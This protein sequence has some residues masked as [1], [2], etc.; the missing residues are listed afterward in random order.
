MVPVV[1]INHSPKHQYRTY[2]VLWYPLQNHP[3]R[4][5]IAGTRGTHISLPHTP[6][7]DIL[8]T[9]GTHKKKSSPQ[10]KYTWY[11][12]YPH[13]AR[14]THEFRTYLLPLYPIHK[15]TH[16]ND[17]CW[18][19]WYPYIAPFTHKRKVR[20][21]LLIHRWTILGTRGTHRWTT[22]PPSQT[23][24]QDILA[25]VVPITQTHTED[26]CWY[27]W[28]PYTYIPPLQANTGLTYWYTDEVS[29]VPV[30]PKYGPTSYPL[31]ATN[32]HTHT[33]IELQVHLVLHTH[34]YTEKSNWY[35]W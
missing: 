16:R 23:R 7:Q 34:T 3:D 20:T 19:P 33:Q 26:I 27:P 30:V 14:H 12:W 11:P 29:L 1:P 8:G 21:N 15:H 17:L 9:R 10:K 6:I 22:H 24:T 2:L 31:N 25:P 35:T 13:I 28:Y 5:S 32:P 18:Y 4:R